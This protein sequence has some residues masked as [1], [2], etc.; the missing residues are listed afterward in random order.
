MKNQIVSISVLICVFL[1]RPSVMQAQAAP[2][3]ASTPEVPLLPMNI[4]F[5]YAPQYFEQSIK[6]DWRYGKIVAL[7]DQGRCDVILLD[8]TMNRE[9]FYSNSNRKVD[10]LAATGA[11]AN[12]TPIDFAAFSTADSRLLFLI[13]FHDQFGQ[14]VTWQFVVGEMEPH[15]SPEVISTT[16][17]SGITFVYAPRRAP[18]VTGT[19]LTIAGR[20]YLPDTTQSNGALAAFY[21]TDMT[22]GR[23]ATGTDLWRVESNPADLMQTARW[24]VDSDDGRQRILAVKQLSETEVAVDQID[25]NDPDS[26]QVVLN[27]VRVNDTFALRS[28]SLETHGNTLW[29]FFGPMLPLPAHQ[30]DD[31]TTVAFTVAENEQANVASGE[32]DVQRAVAAE[33]LLWRFETPNWAKGATFETGVNLIPNGGQQ[34]RCLNEDCSLRSQKK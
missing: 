5:R 21:A 23:I 19:T 8:K 12:I 20:K 30:I 7:V 17:G 11:D 4:E 6:D 9:A 26:P 31:K 29:I 2:A 1:C 14:E 25:L 32:L 18:G 24:D 15:A 10:A 33:H 28:L 22:V 16:H 3:N 13:H 34:A 27:V